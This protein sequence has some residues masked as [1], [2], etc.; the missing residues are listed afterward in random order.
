MREGTIEHR[1]ARANESYRGS[2]GRSEENRDYG[3]RP[4]FFDYASQKL[5]LSRFA[6]G[7]PAPMH[8]LDGLPEEV[9]VDRAPSGR[10][11]RTRASLVAGFERKGMFYSR[12]AAARA[13]AALRSRRTLRSEAARRL[14]P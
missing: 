4:A 7:N 5:Y 8:L 2:G 6:D 13:V 12:K 1:L 14:V 10:V 9:V 11:L 3:F